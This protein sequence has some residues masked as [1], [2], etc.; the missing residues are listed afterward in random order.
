MDIRWT[1]LSLQ[2]WDDERRRELITIIKRKA[3]VIIMA[4]K[5]GTLSASDSCRC[6]AASSGAAEERMKR[7]EEM[8]Y[9]L[10]IGCFARKS[11]MGGTK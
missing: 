7:S 11:M 5:I 6:V 9:A 8:S 4:C 10:T 3:I 2:A 1:D